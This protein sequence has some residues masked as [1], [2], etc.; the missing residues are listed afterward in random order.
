MGPDSL[1]SNSS[2]ISQPARFTPLNSPKG[3]ELDKINTAA[4]PTTDEMNTDMDEDSQLQASI[5]ADTEDDA[6][7]DE[8]TTPSKPP[9]ST[10]KAT[11]SKRKSASAANTP[12]KRSKKDTTEADN[13]D[14]GTPTRAT[15]PPIPT[16]FAAAGTGDRLILSLRDAGKSW[17]EIN[18]TFSETTGIKVGQST[19]RMRYSSMKGNFA[20]IDEADE[21]RLFRFKKEIED[22][23]ENEKWTRIADA[24]IADGGLKYTALTLQKKFKE[25][26]AKPADSAPVA[27]TNGNGITKNRSDDDDEA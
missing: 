27:A 13:E 23:F 7:A 12:S 18:K 9:A 10:K 8:N 24:I 16:T 25:L 19:L 11:P 5:K 6:I 1:T 21:P 2:S 3:Q 15:L 4:A 14:G 26:K 20:V 22:K 17:T